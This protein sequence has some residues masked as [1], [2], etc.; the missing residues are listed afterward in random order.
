[1][2]DTFHWLDVQRIAEELADSDPRLDPYAVNFVELRRL[3]ESLDG[4]AARDGHPA[5]ERIL[6]EIQRLW[7]DEREGLVGDDD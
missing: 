6:E 5:N 1:M 3:V 2:H 7:S 4:F